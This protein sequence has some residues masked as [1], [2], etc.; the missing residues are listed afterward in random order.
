[1]TTL[2]PIGVF[3]HATRLSVRALRNYD[4]LGLLVPARIDP[5]TGYRRYSLEQFARA[6]LIRRLRELEVPLAEIAEILDAGSPDE[7]KAAIERHHDRVAARA[8]ELAA[9]SG[10]LD[11]VLAEPTRWLHVYERVRTP[12]PIACLT[13]E[14]PLSG[15]AER[16]GPAYARLFAALD[17][18]GVTPAGPPGTRYRTDDPDGLSVELFVPVDGPVR[19]DGEIGAGELPGGLLAATIHEGGYEDVETAYRSLGRWIA[20]R[21]RVPTGPAEELY[22]VAPGPSVAPEGYRTEIAWPVTA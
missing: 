21:D 8:A 22:L 5:G 17:A 20:E 16:I 13:I 3:A 11:S 18:Q 6:G 10:G 14:T 1:M 15:L 2:M 7:V 4:R 12:Q 19:D 9:I